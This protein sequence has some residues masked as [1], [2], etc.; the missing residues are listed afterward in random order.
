MFGAGLAATI[1]AALRAAGERPEQQGALG[2]AAVSTVGY[3]GFLAGPSSFGFLAEVVGLS[4]AFGSLSLLALA[5]A[6]LASSVA[7]PARK[8]LP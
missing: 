8:D 4:A 2:I 1:P 3:F 7:S 5:A 6:V